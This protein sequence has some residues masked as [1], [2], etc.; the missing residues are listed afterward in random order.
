MK[1]ILY[2]LLAST[3]FMSEVLP[4]MQIETDNGPVTINIS[5]FDP[6]KHRAVGAAPAEAPQPASGDDK[7]PEAGASDEGNGT[8]APASSENN[9]GAPAPAA[10]E[11]DNTMLVT[12]QGSKYVV[13]N[14]AGEPIKRDG[15]EE[16]GY[17]KEKDA[18]DAIM[19]L[20]AQNNA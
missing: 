5:D 18:W 20:P 14:K 8:P 11:V 2:H 3:A 12:K 7:Q 16:K 9:G 1:R 15:I 17:A 4:T 19:A 6:E 10:A 13:V